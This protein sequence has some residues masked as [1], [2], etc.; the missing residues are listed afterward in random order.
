M[1]SAV[2]AGLAVPVVIEA[3]KSGLQ[4]LNHPAAD[5]ARAALE[6]L[7]GAVN[8]GDV[9]PEALAASNAHIERMMQIETARDN[10]TTQQVN[11][12]LRAE[13]ASTDAYV[14]RMRPTFGYM[15][16]ATWGAQMLALA[17]VIIND[18]GRAGDVLNAMESLSTIWAVALSVLGIYVYQRSA[19]KKAGRL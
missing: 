6:K 2:L 8:S 17:Y 15:M 3:L 18:P 4:Q 13:V 7:Q 19:E 14:R 11:E 1:S 5:G 9:S 16:A 10:A 12:S